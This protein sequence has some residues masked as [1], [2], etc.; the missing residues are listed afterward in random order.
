[1]GWFKDFF[2]IHAGSK[3]CGALNRYI[4]CDGD[5]DNCSHAERNE[6]QVDICPYYDECNYSSQDKICYYGGWQTCRYYYYKVQGG[7]KN[8][9][10]HEDHHDDNGLRDYDDYTDHSHNDHYDYGEDH[11]D[12][13]D[14]TDWDEEHDDSHDD[15][16]HDDSHDDYDDESHEDTEHVDEHTDYKY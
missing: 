3:Y 16:S 15:S 11:D 12:H 2:H 1:M 7:D 8:D 5:C 14:T 6:I 4:E 13:T 9:C 10:S